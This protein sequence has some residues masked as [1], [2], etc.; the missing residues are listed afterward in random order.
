M[1]ITVRLIV[2]AF[3]AL[4]VYAESEIKCDDNGYKIC[5]ADHK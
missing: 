1:K 4:T 5:P 3:L 2:V